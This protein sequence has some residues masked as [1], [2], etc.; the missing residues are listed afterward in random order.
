MDHMFII[1]SELFVPIYVVAKVSSIKVQLCTFLCNLGDFGHV[2]QFALCVEIFTLDILIYNYH[3]GWKHN[4]ARQFAI[5]EMEL[6]DFG[7]NENS[8]W[9]SHVQACFEN[10]INHSCLIENGL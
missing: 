5:E 3:V 6:F 8:T 10:P 9:L 4:K 2:F 7:F 1:T